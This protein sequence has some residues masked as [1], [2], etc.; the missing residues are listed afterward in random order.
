MNNYKLYYFIGMWGSMIMSK[1][2]SDNVFS[3]IWFVVMIVYII[4]FLT[5]KQN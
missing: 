4:L 2:S 3:N 5:N 1:L